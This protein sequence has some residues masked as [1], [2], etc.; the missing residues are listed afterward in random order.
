[1]S[2]DRRCRPGNGLEPKVGS[3]MARA[4]PKCEL[5]FE[6]IAELAD[7]LNTDHGV[8]VTTPAGADLLGS[9]R[10]R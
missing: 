1:M 5:K 2:I 9:S 3:L 4:C 6:L 7:H 8:D 10:K